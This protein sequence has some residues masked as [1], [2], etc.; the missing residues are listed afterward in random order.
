[1]AFSPDGTRIVSGSVDE[2][3]RIW[4][5]KIAEEV[6]EP[7]K[8]HTRYV[9]SVAFSPDGTHIVSGSDDKTINLNCM[10]SRVRQAIEEDIIAKL[11]VLL[12]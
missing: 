10:F 2:T 8:G 9:R 5:A 12:R 11:E 3:I 4:D 1:V 6:F 7:L